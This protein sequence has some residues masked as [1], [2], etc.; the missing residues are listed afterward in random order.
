MRWMFLL[1]LLTM[2]LVAC[3]RE[4][5]S[6][7]PAGTMTPPPARH[8][9][10]A[11]AQLILQNATL[12]TGP[13]NPRDEQAIAVRDG[14]I[15]YLGAI[16]GAEP[17]IGPQTQVDNLHGKLV[18]PGFSDPRLGQFAVD[19]VVNLYGGAKVQDYQQTVAQFIAANP[20]RQLIVGKGWQ[21]S[22][23]GPGGPHKD[24]LDQVNDL[25]PIVLFS[26]DHQSVWV[27]SE[28]IA[29]A[30]INMETADPE[31]GSLARDDNGLVIGVFRKAP[32]MALVEAIIPR[33]DEEPGAEEPSTPAQA[34]AALTARGVFADAPEGAGGDLE[35][36]Q[37]ADFTVLDKNPFQIL[38]EELRSVRVLR[39][40]HRGRPV[41]QRAESE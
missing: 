8:A 20:E 4:D 40:Y 24:H 14:R 15:V 27:N 36:G 41:Y 17:L 29:A 6:H 33:E 22:A 31:G 19:G 23:F 18:L 28:A 1:G 13:G 38:P 7:G 35:L 37:W 12:Y 5:R 16:E 34:V 3:G 32:A 26:A 30:G 21:A 2:L 39:S 9:E 11:P 10:V 25:I